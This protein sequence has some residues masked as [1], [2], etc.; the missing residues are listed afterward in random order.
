MRLDAPR[1]AASEL[2][3]RRYVVRRS[4][5]R[6]EYPTINS[7]VPTFTVLS[8]YSPESNPLVPTCCVAVGWKE[9]ATSHF[10]RPGLYAKPVESWFC[11]IAAVSGVSVEL[12]TGSFPCAYPKRRTVFSV[13]DRS[14]PTWNTY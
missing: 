9:Y 8:S 13:S 10:D 12:G 14:A 3:S 2:S 11:I 5:K 6:N 4:Q 1:R 7:C